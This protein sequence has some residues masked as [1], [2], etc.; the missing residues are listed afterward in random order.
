M[1]MIPE[2]DWESDTVTATTAPEH[3]ARSAFRETVAQVSANA[4]EKLP[5]EINGRL[6]GAV[7]LVL[8]HDVTLCADGSIE[9]GS[10]TDPLKTY[11]LVGTTCECKDFTDGKA[12]QG[13]CRHRIAAGIDKR[14]REVLAASQPAPVEPVYETGTAVCSSATASQTPALPEAPVSITLKATLHG[15]EVLVTLRGTDFA[16]VKAQVEQASQWLRSQP[17]VPQ[18]PSQPQE[19]A[20]EKRYCPRHGTEMTLNH[21]DGRSWWSHKTDQGWCKGK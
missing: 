16:S 21:K 18:A 9:V 20:P 12:P 17:P 5:A 14:V 7:K 15:H 13:W 19:P 1:T 8:S 3:T 6:E 11:R 10:C 2:Y 4:K